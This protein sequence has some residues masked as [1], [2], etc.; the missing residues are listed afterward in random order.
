M[1]ENFA[2]QQ[3]SFVVHILHWCAVPLKDKIASC[4][5]EMKMWSVLVNR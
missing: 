1:W 2:Q 5:A 4:N 3:S